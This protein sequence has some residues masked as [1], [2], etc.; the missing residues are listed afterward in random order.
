MTVSPCVR[1]MSKLGFFV[2][3]FGLVRPTPPLGL[4][5]FLVLIRSLV[6]LVQFEL[7]KHRELVFV[8]WKELVL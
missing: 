1:L 6:H 3:V 8:M 4:T 2:V 5:G 7:A